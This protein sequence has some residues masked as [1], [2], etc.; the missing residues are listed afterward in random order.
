[1]APQYLPSA[2]LSISCLAFSAV[3]T[4]PCSFSCT[5]GLT[6][7]PTVGAALG[8]RGPASRPLNCPRGMPGTQQM[9]SKGLSE[10]KQHV[11]HMGLEMKKMTP[12]DNFLV[13]DHTNRN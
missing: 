13:S 2:T 5:R 11:S 8:G 6:T 3:P 7:P 10:D 12:H 9:C 1:M 4:A